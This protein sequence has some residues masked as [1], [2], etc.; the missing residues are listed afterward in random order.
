LK[1]SVKADSNI[2]LTFKN[3]WHASQF[4]V[5]AE[6][7]LDPN[8]FTLERQSDLVTVSLTEQAIQDGKTDQDLERLLKPYC[9]DDTEWLYNF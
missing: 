4:K 9:T 1:A 3:D 6:S 5:S 7:V 8:D 2:E